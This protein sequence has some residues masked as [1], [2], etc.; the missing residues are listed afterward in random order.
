MESAFEKMNGVLEAV[1]GYTDGKTAN[2]TYE[3]VC[4][5]TT[6]YAEA[7]QVVFDPA[8]VSYEEILETF[9][10]NI[11]PTQV[12]GQFADQGTQYRTAIYYKDERQKKIA[13]DSKRALE[14]SGKFDQ[15]IVVD[16]KPA[17]SFF[18]AEEYHQDYYKKNPGHYKSYHF[19]SG[20]GPYIKKVWG[21]E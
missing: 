6:G 13:E 2:P 4:G 12:N 9:W 8:K 11:D 18:P 15:P 3:E 21:T 14:E 10:H 17:G 1:S 16:I 5:G 7:V 19:F 20:R